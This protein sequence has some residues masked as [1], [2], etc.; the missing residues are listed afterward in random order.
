VLQNVDNTD[1]RNLI[2]Q[3]ITN[4]SVFINDFTHLVQHA[5]QD[6]HNVPVEATPYGSEADVVCGDSILQLLDVRI[7]KRIPLF[8]QLN[9]TTDD[10][11]IYSFH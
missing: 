1:T 10:N 2:L 5:S 11:R 3:I 9:I 7:L 8:Y 6:S 4:S